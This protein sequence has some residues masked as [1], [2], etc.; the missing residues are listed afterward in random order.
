MALGIILTSTGL[1]LSFI[2]AIFYRQPGVPLL[3]FGPV[4]RASQYVT[5]RGAAFW[6]A[7]SCVGMA[8]V[9]IVLWTLAHRV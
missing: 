9:A 3:F 1:V 5:P 2:G 6:V 7:G 4:W 8:G